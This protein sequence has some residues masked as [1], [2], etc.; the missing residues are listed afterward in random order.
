MASVPPTAS[1]TEA[2]TWGRS[3]RLESLV[4]SVLSSRFAS[5]KV[6]AGEH[7]FPVVRAR[8]LD[9]RRFGRRAG[10]SQVP[11]PGECSHA[12]VWIKAGRLHTLVP[13][14]SLRWEALTG[15]VRP[16]S[17]FGTLKHRRAL[18]PLRVRRIE[19]VAL[20]V[21]LTVLARLA[22]ALADARAVPLAV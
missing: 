2:T 21:D 13:R 9:L 16:L 7:P 15:D 14:G 20:H 6:V 18:L 5:L 12:S 11:L 22:C 19:R 3:R 4:A 10:R 1:R 17:E 8:H